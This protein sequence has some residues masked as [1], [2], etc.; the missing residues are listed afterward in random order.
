MIGDECQAFEDRLSLVALDVILPA[1]GGMQQHEVMH[2]K[3]I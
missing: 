1:A 3:L 2:D